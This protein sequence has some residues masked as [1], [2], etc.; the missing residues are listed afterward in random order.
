ML[1]MTKDRVGSITGTKTTRVQQGMQSYNIMIC[2]LGTVL[3]DAG[4]PA[5]VAVLGARAVGGIGTFAR[6]AFDARAAV[7]VLCA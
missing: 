4:L 6:V 1:P 3:V 2:R 7:A 5:A